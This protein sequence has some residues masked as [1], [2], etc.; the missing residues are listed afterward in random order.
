[1]T[2]AGPRT[3]I[4]IRRATAQDGEAFLAL[5]RGLAAYEKLEPPTREA[6]ERL[7]RDAF[8]PAPRI[9]VLLAE[10]ASR[11]IGYAITLETYS[12]FRALPTLYLEDVFVVPEARRL[13]AGR[14][15]LRHLAA[16]ALRRGCGRLEWVVLDWNA[17][18]LGFY[19]KIGARRMSEWIPFRLEGDAL[20]ALAAQPPGDRPAT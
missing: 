15:L 12:S 2:A 5:V 4:V 8:G 1:M 10:V 3:D 20:R 7:L 16:E 18:A 9:E 13:G 6:G 17:L 14:A 19:Q 11:A